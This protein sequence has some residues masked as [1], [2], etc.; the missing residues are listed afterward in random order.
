MLTSKDDRL[1]VVW[2]GTTRAE[3]AQGTPDQSRISPNIPTSPG[4][5]TCSLSLAA[6]SLSLSPTLAVMMCPALPPRTIA[7]IALIGVPREQKMLKGHLTRVM[8]RQV[9]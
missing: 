4:L 1:R 7:C 2:E 9:Y 3:D 5:V 6:L 8:Y